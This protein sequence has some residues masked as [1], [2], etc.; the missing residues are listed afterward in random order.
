MRRAL[1]LVPLLTALCPTLMW[2]EAS[3]EV[4]ACWVSRFGWPSAN[5]D[6]AFGNITRIM[7]RLAE[8][9]F[10]T[11]LFQIRGQCDVHYP[12]P[13]EPW[14]DDY[15]WQD[16]GFDPVAFAVEEAHRNGLEFHAYIN[17]HTLAQSIP[18]EHTEPEHQYNLHGRAGV[19]EN[20]TIHGEDGQPTQTED[21]YVW[22]SP[23]IPEASAWTRQ[24]VLHVVETYDVDGVHFD[25][26]RTPAPE[27]SHDPITQVRFEGIGNPD[28]LGWGDFMRSQITRDLRK[29]YG[30]IRRIDPDCVIS[31]APFG[32]NSRQPGGYQGT[33]TES[34]N[35]WYQDSF[36][37][38]ESHVHDMLF[39][40]I[41]WG[42]GSAHP[43]EV[44][45]ADFMRH[46]GGRHM[47][48]GI[49]S[50]ND[51]LAQIAEARRQGAAGTTIWGRVPYE[52][53]LADLYAEPAPIPERPWL[54]HPTTG[55][56]VGTV[57]D[58]G[59]E[60]VCDAYVRIDEDP[61]TYLSGWDGF[62]AILDVVPGE[63]TVR[64]SIDPE[65]REFTE[66][67]TDVAAGNV[68]DL[69]FTP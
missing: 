42:I 31:S 41:Y 2:A 4:R 25:R 55:I 61:Y 18:P 49:N 8:H 63:H 65:R 19:E 64:F 21:A 50:R 67:A 38:M 53:L 33:G 60:P 39:P 56:V 58:E 30:A 32:I 6:E 54:T 66:V 10:N 44:L 68:V 29:I 5:R 36:V 40:Q 14:S 43:F 22:M 11:V 3:P 47:C 48:A 16:P 69:D 15:D 28:R 26:I 52:D 45:L 27:Y 37:W 62:Y 13:Y 24:A 12:S 17:T 35:E 23:G 51:V 59:G 9:N 7:E 34:R 57:T 20:W 1:A 46:T